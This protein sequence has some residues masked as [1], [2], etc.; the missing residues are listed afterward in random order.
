[1]MSGHEIASLDIRNGD[2]LASAQGNAT[3]TVGFRP[4]PLPESGGTGT[5]ATVPDELQF[6]GRPAFGVEYL[7]AREIGLQDRRRRI[8]NPVP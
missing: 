8:E 3:R 6:A 1:M 7:D 2:P 4:H 5:E